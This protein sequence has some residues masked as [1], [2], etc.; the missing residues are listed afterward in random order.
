[1]WQIS[2]NSREVVQELI[3]KFQQKHGSKGEQHSVP[4]K[5]C[6]FKRQ[7]MKTKGHCAGK[8]VKHCKPTCFIKTRNTKRKPFQEVSCFPWQN[9]GISTASSS[10]PFKGKH[11]FQTCRPFCAVMLRH[12]TIPQVLSVN[13]HYY[14][15]FIKSE[16]NPYS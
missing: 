4:L 2:P 13:N 14:F 6:R 3:N 16:S 5:I 12:A 11:Q 7:T 15:N 8:L 10:V 1:M 9:K